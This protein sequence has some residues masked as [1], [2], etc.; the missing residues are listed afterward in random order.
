MLRRLYGSPWT[1]FNG[2]EDIIADRRAC[3]DDAP[4]FDRLFA[5]Q[6]AAIGDPIHHSPSAPSHTLS[7]ALN[8]G[9]PLDLDPLASAIGAQADHL[10]AEEVRI[11]RPRSAPLQ[12]NVLAAITA[13]QPA[14]IHEISSYHPSDPTF[15]VYLSPPSMSS[16]NSA[17][18]N[19]IAQ[20]LNYLPNLSGVSM[21]TLE[22]ARDFT[23]NNSPINN[24][25][26]NQTI[27]K[28]D[29]SE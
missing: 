23:L 12:S 11:P 4:S 9:E 27:L 26:G 25:V 8:Q 18:N 10:Q 3:P 19:P 20:E 28:I 17:S 24:V 14:P 29:G 5:S 6:H 15:A 7:P 16:V 1:L 2:V 22:G 21:S 13:D